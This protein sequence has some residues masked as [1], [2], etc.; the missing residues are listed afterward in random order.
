MLDAVNEA[1]ADGAEVISLHD[2][3]PGVES[4]LLRVDA[5]VEA[6]E[7][8]RARQ[9]LASALEEFGQHAALLLHLA[10]LEFD[11]DQYERADACFRRAIALDPVDPAVASQ[12]ARFLAKMGMER[13]AVGILAELSGEAGH[14]PRIRAVLGMTYQGAGWRALAVD[15]YGDP[16][17]LVREARRG[18]RWCWWHSGGPL[19]SVRRRV[20]AVEEES[21]HTWRSW[22]ENLAVLDTL[23]QPRGFTAELVKGEV[24]GYLWRRALAWTR[25][26]AFRRW[27]EHRMR[28]AVVAL[29]LLGIFGVLVVTRPN[30]DAGAVALTATV[31]TVG[32]W[33]LWA[34]F[35]Q[36]VNA[37]ESLR[38]QWARAFFIGIALAGG[39]VALLAKVAVPPAWPGVLGLTLVASLCIAGCMFVVLNTAGVIANA[40]LARLWRRNPRAAL[41]ATLADLLWEIGHPDNRNHLEIRA[42]WIWLLEIAA[43]RMQKDMPRTLGSHDPA[44]DVWLAERALGAATALRRLKRHIAAPGPQSWDRLIGELRHEA[45]AL[46]TGDLRALR[47]VQPPLPELARKGLRHKVL[48]VL[49][50]AVAIAV[51]LAAAVAFQVLDLGSRYVTVAWVVS[52]AWAIIY[53]LAT[54]DP[55]MPAK[56]ELARGVF[57]DPGG[58]RQPQ[59]PDG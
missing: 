26:R 58:S 19:A 14:H 39:S 9:A 10:R 24:D 3:D 46:A 12:Y 56:I 11:N 59:G 55:T 57:T 29:T 16:A 15:A 50:V 35:R 54:I 27:A 32:G 18:R 48:V 2:V 8:V 43:T 37:A 40:A 13:Q 1:M 52:I 51:P 4:A 17:G 49:R 22:A 7:H 30:A 45:T 33:A 28:F 53:L 20:R 38:G 42:H 34:G 5:L 47:W 31:S 25:W 21:R 36:F 23:D 41:L 6:G 44:T